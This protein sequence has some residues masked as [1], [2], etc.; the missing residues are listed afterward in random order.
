MAGS[1]GDI[2]PPPGRPT[3]LKVGLLTDLSDI[4]E[5]I[6]QTLSLL[7]EELRHKFVDGVRSLLLD[8]RVRCIRADELVDQCAP[9]VSGTTV[10]TLKNIAFRVSLDGLDELCAATLRAA[11][12][13][14]A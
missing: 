6:G 12:G 14:L 9:D 1:W 3:E 10:R 8:G 13:N 2:P 11:H 5:K 4:E 7:P